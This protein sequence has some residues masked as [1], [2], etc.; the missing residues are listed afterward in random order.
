MRAHGAKV[1]DIV[2]LVVSAAGGVQPQTVEAINHAKAANVPMIVAINKIDLPNA[3]PRKVMQDLAAYDLV[4]EEWG[5]KTVMLEISAK[6]GINLDKLLDLIILQAELMELK[7]NP[8]RKGKAIVIEARRDSKKGNLATVINVAGVIK[9]GDPFIVG[10]A[11]GKIRAMITD[12]GER[13]QNIG[14]S[15]PA[16]ILGITGELPQAGDILRV[17]ESEKEA[18]RIAE[19][20]QLLRKQETF[21]HQKQVSLLSLKSQI[22]RNMV[23]TLNIILKTDVYGSLQALKDSLEKLSIAEVGVNILHAGVGNIAES[24]L[25][26][27]KASNAIIFGFHVDME[28]KIA[29]QSKK[30]GIEIRLYKVIYDLLED[31]KAA[32][33]GMLE[34]EIVESVTG[35]AE[36]KQVFELR[37]GRVAGSQI[38]EGRITRNQ[39]VKILRSGEVVGTGK[40]SGLKRFKEDVKQVDKGLECGIL[41]EGYRDFQ[42][43]DI[44]EGIVKEQKIRRLSDV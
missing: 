29:E 34:P 22:D 23:K 21:S 7:G 1:T 32:M 27:A 39:E 17:M 25:L 40:V 35:R 26:L 44:I 43:G 11:Y 8:A 41:I 14:L 6:K 5:G 19:K 9:V 15:C 37:T 13:I 24:D 36:I 30:E 28:P 3:N 4:P 10:A 33:S 31:V 38:R 2:V 20:R 16:E 18:R 12:K 42:V